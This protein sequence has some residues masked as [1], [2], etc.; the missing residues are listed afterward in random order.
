MPNDPTGDVITTTATGTAKPDTDSSLEPEPMTKLSDNISIPTALFE[1]L[2]T[3]YFAEGARKEEKKLR[4]SG[5]LKTD[6]DI[7][8]LKEYEAILQEASKVGTEPIQADNLTDAS[9]ALLE[10]E[11]QKSLTKLQNLQKSFDEQMSRTEEQYKTQLSVTESKWERASSGFV[12]KEI[13]TQLLKHDANP[14]FIEM[15]SESWAKHFVVDEDFRIL[16][17]NEDERERYDEATKKMVPVSVS[18]F[19]MNNLKD[20]MKRAT[21]TDGAGSTY[22]N[23]PGKTD[24]FIDSINSIIEKNTKKTDGLQEPKYYVQNGRSEPVRH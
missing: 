7:E 13:E 6:K 11:R 3:R 21:N 12:R 2:K 5:K 9:K 19:V 15:L 20:S 14:D 16:I 22:A 1:N 24:P 4:D 23:K 17:K 18:D 10:Q 8:A